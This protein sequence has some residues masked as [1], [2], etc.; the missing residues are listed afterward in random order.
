MES[1]S[2]RLFRDSVGERVR[3]VKN[4]ANNTLIRQICAE[5]ER[6]GSQ[7]PKIA[8]FIPAYEAE[9][10]IGDTLRR[11][12]VDLIP[13][14]QCIRVVD[15]AS[16]DRTVEVAQAFRDSVSWRDK[17]LVT[18][19]ARNLGYGGN[20]IAAYEW[21]IAAGYDYVVMVHGDGQYA[22]EFLGN[23]IAQALDGKADA[24]LG[25]RMMHKMSAL[26]GGMPFYKWVGN[27]VLTRAQNLILGTN[28]HEFH[29]GY[30]LY[31]TKALQA[32]PFAENDAGFSFDT[33]I[34]IQL[35]ALNASIV[36]LPYQAFYG[37]EKCHVDGLKYAREVLW[38]AVEYR[39]HQLHLLRRQRYLVKSAPRYQRKLSPY[40]SH[41]TVLKMVH[42]PARVL[43]L[44]CGDGQVSAALAD[45]GMTV[46]GVD[47]ESPVAEGRRALAEFH[48]HDLNQPLA[49][50]LKQGKDFDYVIMAD[51]IEHLTRR[52]ELLHDI[53]SFLK[54][55]GCLIVSTPNIANWYVRLSLLMGRFNYGDRG[56]LDRTHVHF[57]TLDSFISVIRRA[58]FEIE[59]V[60]GTS[61]PFELILA[62]TG[63]SRIC[64]LVDRL[65]FSL[66]R[67]W[68]KLFAYQLVIKA[69]PAWGRGD[70]L[71]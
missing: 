61:L 15:D 37:D 39:L 60:E 21:A 14:L 24:V 65:Y 29:T 20:Q 33:Q 19:N 4:S 25:S 71:G 52:D 26:A 8:V 55:D 5:Q 13:A 54:D 50:T 62:S 9:S 2:T 68:P 53:R 44:G 27:Q 59:V 31:S 57:Y 66:V 3:R 45:K 32:I 47:R 30:R 11:I 7:F 40:G 18:R 38:A 51:V 28:L 69:R 12:P 43:E 10:L 63:R 36:E 48:A 56:I 17:L 16:S 34:L 41:E 67:L 64:R 35:R 46:C 70:S 1:T 42:G 49:L 23:L 58:G 6:L 22:P